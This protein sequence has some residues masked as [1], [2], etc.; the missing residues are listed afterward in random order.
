METKE[1]RKVEKMR[2]SLHFA[3]GREKGKH[4]IFLDGEEELKRWKSCEYFDTMPEMSNRSFNRPRKEELKSSGAEIVGGTGVGG[5]MV[6]DGVDRKT[7]RKVERKRKRAYRELAQREERVKK[8]DLLRLHLQSHK[9]RQGKGRR[10]KVRDADG[11]RPAQ[12]KWKK[13]RKR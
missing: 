5:V 12:Y 2:A 11:D 4:T 13:Q 3:D 8:M 9:D 7:L 6:P 1:R 10:R